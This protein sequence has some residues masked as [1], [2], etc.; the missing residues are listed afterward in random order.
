M[1]GVLVEFNE[2][3]GRVVQIHVIA[4]TDQQQATAEYGFARITNPRI[5][6]WLCRLVRIGGRPAWLQSPFDREKTR[7][8]GGR[9]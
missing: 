2:I 8:R 1:V 7:D 3:T 6:H 9:S 4:D 5:W